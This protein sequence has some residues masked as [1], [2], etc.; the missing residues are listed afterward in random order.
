MSDKM[1]PMQLQTSRQGDVGRAMSSGMIQ[2]GQKGCGRHP[3]VSRTRCP[4][5]GKSCRGGDPCSLAEVTFFNGLI[6]EV[7]LYRRTLSAGEVYDLYDFPAN[8]R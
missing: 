4:G 7:R 6:D 5:R 3:V 2:M 8:R 1:S